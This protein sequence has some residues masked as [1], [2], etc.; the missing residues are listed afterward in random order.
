MSE[1]RWKQ[2]FSDFSRAYSYLHRAVDLDRVRPLSELERL[3]LIHCFEFTHELAWNVLKDY[4]TEQGIVGL[5]GSKDATRSA[6]SNQLIEDGEAWMKM[7]QSRN[8]TSHTYNVD[9][10][11]EVVQDILEHYHAAFASFLSKFST[12]RDKQ[13]GE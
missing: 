1:L 5:V 11:N 2:R 9:I 7:I 13:E 6:F 10:A 12:L 4:L 3:G 8:L